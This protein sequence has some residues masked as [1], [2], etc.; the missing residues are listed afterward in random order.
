MD[1][2]KHILCFHYPVLLPKRKYLLD[3]GM[4]EC[5]ERGN[6]GTSQD[7]LYQGVDLCFTYA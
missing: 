7:I 2:I 1:I 6:A 4:L 3:R 5:E